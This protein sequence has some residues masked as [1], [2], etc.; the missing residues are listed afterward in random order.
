M[1]PLA[2]LYTPRDAMGSTRM[3]ICRLPNAMRD[4]LPSFPKDADVRSRTT[5][6]SQATSAGAYLSGRVSRFPSPSSAFPPSPSELVPC[7]LV[8]G[9][10]SLASVPQ[11]SPSL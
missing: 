7:P 8:P 6:H 2:I 5:A 10:F 1:V 4:Q 11:A 9:L 3:G